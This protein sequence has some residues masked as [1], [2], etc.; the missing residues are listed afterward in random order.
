MLA[1]SFVR[2]RHGA[3]KCQFSGASIGAVRG[4]ALADL[5]EIPAALRRTAKYPSLK[6]DR[7]VNSLRAAMVSA[8]VLY[9]DT[10]KADWVIADQIYVRGVDRR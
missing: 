3:W 9:A 1:Q 4:T 6:M 8:S 10:I 7:S 5:L 2:A